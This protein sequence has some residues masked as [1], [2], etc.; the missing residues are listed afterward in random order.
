MLENQFSLDEVILT[1]AY[2]ILEIEKQILYLQENDQLNIPVY[3]GMGQEFIAATISAHFKSFQPA[4]FAQHRAHSYFVAF[5][6]D[7]DSLIAEVLGDVKNGCAK[8]YGG[9]VGIYSKEISMF[10]HTGLMGEQV[11]LGT[12]WAYATRK[13]TIV[14]MGDATIEEDYVAPALGFAAMQEL[15]VIFVCEDN[16]LAVL[17]PTEKRRKWR[18]VDLARAC[19]L[20]SFDIND[21]PR[22]MSQIFENFDF[23]KPIFMNIHTRR[24]NRH[25]GAQL[26]GKPE[27]D[28]LLLFESYFRNEYGSD[29]LNQI[30][31]KCRYVE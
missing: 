5:G 4:I 28:R 27:W 2:E 16:G 31:E 21:D 20:E 22:A 14:V 24:K 6:G 9:S 8:G 17:T 3:L 15:P 11:Y 25:V 30:R 1:K 12:G 13:P 19:G 23:K 18:S 26:E 29:K 7:T 10:G